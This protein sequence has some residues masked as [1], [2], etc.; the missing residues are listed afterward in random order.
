MEAQN[1]LEANNV[2]SLA[3]FALAKEE[4]TVLL[5]VT[6]SISSFTLLLRVRMCYVVATIGAD[7]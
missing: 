4:R 3:V 1:I 2:L 5:C 6:R 7:L